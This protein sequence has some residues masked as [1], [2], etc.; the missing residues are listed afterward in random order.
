MRTDLDKLLDFIKFTHELRKIKRQIVL[1]DDQNENDAEHSYQ[2]AMLA[3][4]II[5]EN[6]LNLDRYRCMAMAL[7]HD[8][9]EVYAGDLIVFAPQKELVD[10]AAREQEAVEQLAQDWPNISSLH[11]LIE[12]YE[13]RKTPEAKFVYALD[14]LIPE[15]NNYLYGGKAWKKHGIKVEQVK[16][17]KKGKVDINPTIGNYHKQIIKLIEANPELFRKVAK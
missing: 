3:M 15:I 8:V 9:I 14:K 13:E 1:D 16:E 6:N 12:E 4:F 17:V 11:E 5:D 10:K 7:V 2:M